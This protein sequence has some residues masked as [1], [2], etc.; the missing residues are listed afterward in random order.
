MNCIILTEEDLLGDANAARLAGRRFEHITK[1]L[2]AKVGD[3]VTVGLLGGLLG[4]GLLTRIDGQQLE[5]EIR[6][7]RR[8]PPG[9][10]IT[11]IVALPRPKSMR[12]VIHAATTMGVKRIFLI[13]TWRVEKSYWQTPWLDRQYLRDLMVLGLEQS[14]DTVMPD[15]QIRRKFKPFVQDEIP[16]LIAG[17]T[18]LV[19]HPEAQTCCPYHFAGPLTLAIGPEA[20]FT[21]YEIGE[22]RDRGFRDVTIGERVL[23]VEEAVAALLGRLAG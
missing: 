8:P 21:D 17:T 3:T 23:R 22:L 12:K 1:V 15:L 2:R 5:M 13:E 19:A 20:G 7:D 10:A 11:L 18:P 16:L 6:L 4:T 14:V 9:L